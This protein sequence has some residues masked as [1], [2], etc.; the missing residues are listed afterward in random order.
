MGYIQRVRLITAL[1]KVIADG[2]DE[3]IGSSRSDRYKSL[4]SEG[5]KR[6][7]DQE[8]LRELTNLHA[9]RIKFN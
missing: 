1:Q 2:S 5:V 4:S 8:L 7:S 9:F 6:L 3:I